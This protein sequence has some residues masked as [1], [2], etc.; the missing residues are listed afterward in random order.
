MAVAKLFLLAVVAWARTWR[1]EFGTT[2]HEGLFLYSARIV[3]GTADLA[4]L[5]ML[6]AFARRSSIYLAVAAASTVSRT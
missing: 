3:S 1:W 4:I 6:A 5:E 2:F